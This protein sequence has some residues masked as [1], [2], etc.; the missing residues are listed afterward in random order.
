M[1]GRRPGVPNRNF[2]PLGLAEALLVP[3][4]IQDEASGTTVSRLTLAELLSVSPSSSR[5][6]ELIAASRFYGLSSGGI[7]ADEFAITQLG[8][9]A[10][11]GDEVAVVEGLK[12]AVRNVAPFNKFLVTFN[13]K[14]VP[15]L[16]VF[17]EFLV[18]EA[19]VP[20]DHVDQAVEH[21]LADAETA[22]FL[23]MTKGGRYVD[24]GAEPVAAPRGD[25]EDGETGHRDEDAADDE[26]DGMPEML[27]E[28]PIPPAAPSAEPA[29]PK[30]VFIAHGKNRVP[31]EQ[32]KKALDTFKVKYAVAV[33]EP[34]KGRPIS[35][36]VASLMRD[37]CSS[38]IFIFTAD[39]RFLKEVPD[40]EPE[41]VWRPSEN[42]VFELGRHVDPLRE[43]HRDLQGERRRVPQRL[44]RPRVHRVR[45]GP[46]GNRDRVTVQ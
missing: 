17:K 9:Q 39:E 14:K 6:R 1:P 21:L 3:R 45:E 41:E 34:S 32:L 27:V 42:V 12:K 43:P 22:G 19:E 30:K 46:A 11:G 4:K 28:P 7:N 38:G 33:D 40:G 2:P 20:Q 13:N 10:V 8:A 16:V 25:E 24:F 26:L 29:A 37:E 23:R 5:F 36:K 18:K 35:K 44:L 31:L 15:S